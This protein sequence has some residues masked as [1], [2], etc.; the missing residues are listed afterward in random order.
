MRV[1][2]TDPSGAFV[3]MGRVTATEVH[4][5]RTVATGECVE[6]GPLTGTVTLDGER[7]LVV[8]QQVVRL[9]LEAAGPRV[10]DLQTTLDWAQ[11]S[12]LFRIPSN[13]RP[14]SE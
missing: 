2:P 14:Q 11:R 8:R 3:E 13:G 7:H 4:S 9:T 10:V 12:G 5:V 1:Q 6:V